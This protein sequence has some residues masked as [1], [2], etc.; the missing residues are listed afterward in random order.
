MT[1][2]SALAISSWRLLDVP[3]LGL[4]LDS[5]LVVRSSSADVEGNDP[6]LTVSRG[7]RLT[8][9]AGHQVQT[10]PD[11]IS[12]VKNL[13]RVPGE[14]QRVATEYQ[15]VRP[16]HRFTLTLR[17]NALEPG[18]L[19]PG[20][21]PTDKLVEVDGRALPG[22]VG[23]EGLKS[24][25]ASRPEAVLGFEREN[26]VFAGTVP[27]V[28]G[29][30]QMGHYALFSV[31][32]LLMLAIWRFR[33]RKIHPRFAAAV[34][35]ETAVLSTVGLV[36]LRPQWV[37]AD[38]V[39][40]GMVVAGL[41]LPR[42]IAFLGRAQLGQDRE[43]VGPV[44]ALVL[45][46][47][48][49]TGVVVLAQK[50]VLNTE[51]GL[52]FSAVTGLMFILY[53]LVAGVSRRSTPDLG[54]ERGI[55]LTG[56]VVLSTVAGLFA[57]LSNPVA[58]VEQQWVPFSATVL[59][60]MWFGDTILTVR[61]PA[62]S[63]LDEITSPEARQAKIL[64]YF[65]AVAV[66]TGPARFRLVLFT[67]ERSIALGLGIT[68]F[69]ASATDQALHDAVSIL[70]REGAQVPSG[71]L[72]HDDPLVGIAETMQICLATRLA[73]PESGIEI[74][75]LAVIL[76]GFSQPR[77]GERVAP[78]PIVATEV[79]H[80][81]MTSTIWASALLEGLP[82]L[83]GEA[84]P[85]P[86]EPSI[87][88]EVVAQL[89]SQIAGMEEENTELAERVDE[90][91]HVVRVLGG[92]TRAPAVP[93]LLEEELIEAMEFLLRAEEPV[94]LGGPK[95]AGK[96]FIARSSA[97]LD[98]L[99]SGP[100]VT[101]DVTD[102]VD[103]SGYSEVDDLPDDLLHAASGGTVIVRGARLLDAH[104]V[105]ALIH[106]C[107]GDARLYFLFDDEDAE[108]RSVLEHYPDDLRASLEHR[109][110]IVPGF[111]RRR[112]IL[113]PVVQ[114]LVERAAIRHQKEV[115]GI[116]AEAM[117]ELESF[118]FPGHIAQ[119][120]VMVDAAVA[121]ADTDV[122]EVEDFPGL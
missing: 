14:P 91:E 68:G 66:E 39:L 117:R 29:L 108:S 16:L 52:Q 18:S 82:F 5:N 72:G 56:V 49:A 84:T 43:S 70:V 76:V 96:E 13:S 78:A 74:P 32:I 113:A 85:H 116:A 105:K 28:T 23:P 93:G 27:L 48:A 119:C 58:F 47:V 102:L 25:V 99:F 120:V 19:P 17:G 34:G 104:Q 3:D 69:E 7:D 15:A 89:R 38:I 50:G 45:A 4:S 107:A 31:V 110:V 36:V 86:A 6:Q 1:V 51:N 2:L 21:E 37:E 41:I 64:D 103:E 8:A 80:K 22:K 88:H 100:V 90:L 122:L 79:A 63:G 75:R 73:V 95:G 111:A 46:I 57:Y 62:T 53:E 61:G 35:I 30:I 44:I 109:E 115:V 97:S 112:G 55:F 121:R 92:H 106:R 40:T 59:G 26:A 71:G 98:P 114:Y 101:F 87:S 9:I 81:A 33:D 42:P 11:V 65:D 12:L 94:V 20:I 77:P 10:L 60:L 54:P 67:E 24:I 118:D 83:S